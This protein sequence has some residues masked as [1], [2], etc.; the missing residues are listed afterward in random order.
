MSD[1]TRIESGTRMSQAVIHNGMPT[2]QAKWALKGR[3]LPNKPRRCWPL[4]TVYWQK[5]EPTKPN[6]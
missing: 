3:L 5:L 4:L 1:I 6:F 2:S